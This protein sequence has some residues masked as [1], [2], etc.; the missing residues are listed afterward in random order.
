M[1]RNC[2]WIGKDVRITCHGY[3]TRFLFFYFSVVELAH[4]Q[5]RPSV[6]VLLAIPC[7]YLKLPVLRSFVNSPNKS[8]K[9][10]Y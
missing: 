10:F 2:E 5:V 9:Y 4:F 1:R 6:P 7:L 8:D 3:G